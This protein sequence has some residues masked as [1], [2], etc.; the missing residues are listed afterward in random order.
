MVRKPAKLLMLDEVH[1]ADSGD[2][3]SRWKFQNVTFRA[4]DL[5]GEQT[6]DWTR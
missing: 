5:V 1:H 4:A 2:G 6:T 3:T